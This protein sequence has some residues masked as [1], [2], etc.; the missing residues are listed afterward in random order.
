[1]TDS[2]YVVDVSDTHVVLGVVALF[3]REI[4][5]GLQGNGNGILGARRQTGSFE[6]HEHLSPKTSLVTED[7]GSTPTG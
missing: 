4:H 2:F 5:Y 6:G 1:M 7:G 3:Y